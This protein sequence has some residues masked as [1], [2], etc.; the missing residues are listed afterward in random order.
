MG[1]AAEKLPTESQEEEI[2]DLTHEAV[3]IPEH[4]SDVKDALDEVRKMNSPEELER[5]KEE[6]AQAEEAAA[7]AKARKEKDRENLL[8]AR[9][10][11]FLKNR[12]KIEGEELQAHLES[13]KEKEEGSE[14]PKKKGFFAR[15]FGKK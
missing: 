14:K 7:Q 5:I 2:V 12:E 1:H 8:K 11:L 15:L 13:L 10:H 3:E 4:P 6:K 9:E